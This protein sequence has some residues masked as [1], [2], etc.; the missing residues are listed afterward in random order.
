MKAR[1]IAFLME[2]LHAVL[3]PELFKRVL[4][5]IID[6][7]ENAIASSETKTDDAVLLPLI[8]MLRT[9]LNIPDND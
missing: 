3:T 5:S 9:S 7:L 1:V 6:V 2:Q 8:A 4:D